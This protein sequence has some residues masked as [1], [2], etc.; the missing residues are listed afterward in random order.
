MDYSISGAILKKKQRF[1]SKIS[2]PPANS[3]MNNE[4]GG[5]ASPAQTH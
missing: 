4:F 5:I 2:P 3:S 1:L